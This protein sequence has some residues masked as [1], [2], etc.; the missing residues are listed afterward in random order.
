M[1][2]NTSVAFRHNSYSVSCWFTVTIS[3]LE[4]WMLYILIGIQEV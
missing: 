2:S 3:C 1:I 4:S